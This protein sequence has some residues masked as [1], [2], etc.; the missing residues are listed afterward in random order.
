M[1]ELNQ[2]E[3]VKDENTNSSENTKNLKPLLGVLAGVVVIGLV[4]LSIL[5]FTSTKFKYFSLVGNTFYSLTNGIEELTESVFGRILNVN[6]N[7]KLAIDTEIDASVDTNDAEIL[8]WLNGFKSVKLKAYENTDLAGN[9][10]DSNISVAL[11]GEEFILADLLRRDNIFSVNVDGITDGYI[12]ADNNRLTELWEKIGYVGPDK[13]TSQ[14]ELIADFGLYEDEI[15]ELKKAFLRVGKAF[16]N[17]FAVS[18]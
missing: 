15:K 10:F 1:D 11:N 14:V 6:L 5:T 9:Y 18:S 12:S 17:A 2:N 4:V 8:A 13:F 3:I 7:K 16:T